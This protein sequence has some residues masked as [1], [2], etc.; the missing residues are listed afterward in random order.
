MLIKQTI[1]NKWS[2]WDDI[3]RTTFANIFTCYIFKMEAEMNMTCYDSSPKDE[4]LNEN[5]AYGDKM[6]YKN[7]Q[8][9]M[10]IQSHF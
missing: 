8:S 5:L 1:S 7:E 4:W 10:F 6:W 3:V 2:K 9:G